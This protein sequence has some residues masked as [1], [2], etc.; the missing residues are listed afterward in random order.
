MIIELIFLLVIGIFT[1]YISRLLK[2][3]DLL[4]L[5]IVGMIVGLSGFNLVGNI[6]EYKDFFI[7]LALIFIL[8]K[9]G[10]GIEES[11]LKKIG[12]PA[13]LL[14][15]I[16]CLFEGLAITTLAIYFLG[17]PLIEALALG[18]IIAAV[19]PAIVVPL[20]LELKEKKFKFNKNIPIMNLA[21]ISID[22]VVAISIFSIVISIFT[23]GIDNLIGMFITIPFSIIIAII[24]A[25]YLVKVLLWTELK[26]EAILTL[27]VVYVGLLMYWE[28]VIIS[29][30]VLAMSIGYY[31]NHLSPKLK[32]DILVPVNNIWDI[33]KILLFTLIGAQVNLGY[34]DE[35]L[36]IG[37][38]IIFIALGIRM[39][40]VYISLL[41]T[42]YNFKEKIYIGLCNI[43]KA[44]VQASLGAIP[45]SV[46]MVNGEEILAISVIAIISTVIIA[47]VLITS[48][49]KR[50]LEK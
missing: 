31:I 41:K 46:G 39:I 12:R 40:G 15:F 32:K 2:V 19:S 22:D 27:S 48:L 10:L 9:A 16:P 35:Y 33:L 23:N 18:F 28:V 37:L 34:I 21:A 30:L 29:P 6:L 7:K 8:I 20:M 17:F 43:P 5:L 36:F 50:L 45:L 49:E 44:T 47:I 11:S 24:L 14:G 26:K 42:E 25:K 4:L 1:I 3:P 13:I 38:F